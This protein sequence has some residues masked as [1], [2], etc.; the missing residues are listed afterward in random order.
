MSYN[1][2]SAELQTLKNITLELK[3]TLNRVHILGIWECV[4]NP[5]FNYG[6]FT[7]I[8]I[9]FLNLVKKINEATL[10]GW[11]RLCI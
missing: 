5:N 9:N 7:I 10:L 2:N 4:Y 11:P 8:K 6:E 1:H 3:Q